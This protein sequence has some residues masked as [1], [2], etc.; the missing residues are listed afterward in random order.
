[1]TN[2]EKLMEELGQLDNQQ[3]INV[4]DDGSLTL[5]IDEYAC[6]DCK[7]DHGGECPLRGDDDCD[8]NALKWLDMPCRH[9]QLLEMEASA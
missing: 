4:L 9:D 6:G 8:G 1:M 7:A 3:L 5:L 2:R